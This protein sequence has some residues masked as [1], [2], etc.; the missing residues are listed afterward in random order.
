[1]QKPPKLKLRDTAAFHL[2]CDT[3]FLR[4][5]AGYSEF[6]LHPTHLL[7]ARRAAPQTIVIGGAFSRVNTRIPL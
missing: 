4:V 3:S 2:S 1:M 5:D 6:L 7:D